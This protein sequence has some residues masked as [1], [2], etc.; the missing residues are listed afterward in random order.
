M[1][2]RGMANPEIAAK[3]YLSLHTVKSHINHIFAK[4]GSADRSSAVRY[5]R[6]HYLV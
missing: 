3:L 4:T 5:A 2:A 1:I 6:D